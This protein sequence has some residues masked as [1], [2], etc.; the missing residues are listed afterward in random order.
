MSFVFVAIYWNNHHHLLHAVHRV[1]GRVL[2]ANMHLLFW[3][4]LV[5]FTT[6]WMG[7]HPGAA[8]PVA[9]YGAVLLASAIAYTVLTRE[10]LALHPSDSPL[11]LAIGRDRK[12]KISLGLYIAAIP[13]TLLSP[14]LAI[15]IFVTVTLLWL[16]PDVRLERALARE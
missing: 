4:S 7:E 1:N 10:L 6:A 13:L 15:A 3:L 12:G 11:A 2:W 5:P 8:T 9:L 16:V 14:W